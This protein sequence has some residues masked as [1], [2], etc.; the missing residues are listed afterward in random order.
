MIIRHLRFL[1]VKSDQ[2]YLAKI[3][4]PKSPY[5]SQAKKIR[6]FRLLPTFVVNTILIKMKKQLLLL[7]AC[8]GLGIAAQAQTTIPNSGFETWDN[9]SASN[10]EP[11]NWNS[12]RTGGGFATAGPQTCFR[13]T[14]TLGGGAYCT[15]VETGTAV[16]N[17]VNGSCTTGK[18][19]APTFTKADGYIHTIPG[20]AN[21]SA[22]FTGRPDSLVFWFRYA[23]QGSDSPSV[24]ARLHVGNCYVP[25]TPSNT[26]HPDS[27]VNIIA[28]AEWV[29]TNTTQ[30]TWQ[31]VSVPFVYVAGAAGARTP[32]YILITMTGSSNNLGGTNGT[33]LWVDEMSAV[34]NPNGINEVAQLSA[35]PY[36]RNGS[37][38]TDLSGYGLTGASLQLFSTSGQLI[39]EHRLNG[40]E[41]N[42]TPVE[43]AT[44][45]YIYRIVSAQATTTGKIVKQ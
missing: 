18:V 33:I 2:D 44:G 11:T 15:K 25:E 28:R 6:L 37:L 5:L 40:N 29:G 45:V 1:R 21:N 32:E 22:P 42:V 12:N 3:K 24:Q 20:D 35:K 39:S 9:V 26:N 16:G 23:P 19:E 38:V 41:M 30:A 7:I 8:T 36:W 13:D 43:A 14:S 4:N 10:A 27:S 17:V 31:R 34:Y